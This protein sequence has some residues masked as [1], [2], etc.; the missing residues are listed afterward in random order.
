M[1]VKYTEQETGDRNT[2][3]MQVESGLHTE[4][5][6]WVTLQPPDAQTPVV[7]APT[8]ELELK[9]T[10]CDTTNEG[11]EF[12][13]FLWPNTRR[14][15]L[16]GEFT[17]LHRARGAA[18]RE[19]RLEDLARHA[20]PAELLDIGIEQ[21]GKYGN[22]DRL[23]LLAQ[24]L[25]ES[26]CDIFHP[27]ATWLSTKRPEA[28]FFV[29]LVCESDRLNDDQRD[30]LLRLLCLNDEEA[31]RES[32]LSHALRLSSRHALLVARSLPENMDVRDLIEHHSR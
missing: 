31:V 6:P 24:L 15:F 12:D 23:S 18:Q 25:D 14:D 8:E 13:M 4:D 30:H 32:L 7:P 9:P 22:D 29:G 28:L 11:H 10:N 5:E 3:V 19:R 2:T 27:L 21:H 16:G 17:V 26:K 1:A 20:F